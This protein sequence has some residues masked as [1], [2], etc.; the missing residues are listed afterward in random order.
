MGAHV[1]GQDSAGQ[2]LFKVTVHAHHSGLT[3]FSRLLS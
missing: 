1:G 2:Y 3:L